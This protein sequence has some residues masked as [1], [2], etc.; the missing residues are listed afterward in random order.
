MKGGTKM[1]MYFI[2]N[3]KN[4]DMKLGPLGRYERV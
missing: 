2:V 1:K 4:E 3:Q